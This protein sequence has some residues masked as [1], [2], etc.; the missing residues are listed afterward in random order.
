MTGEG[1]AG[2]PWLTLLN[3]PL[4]PT[5]KTEDTKVCGAVTREDVAAVVIK[6]LLSKASDGKVR[7][8]GVGGCAGCLTW[9]CLPPWPGWRVC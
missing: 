2:A 1:D 9:F 5:L 3:M 8:G 7:N 6:A 4:S